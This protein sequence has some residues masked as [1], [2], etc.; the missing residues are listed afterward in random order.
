VSVK[1]YQNV[2]TY[3]NAMSKEKVNPTYETA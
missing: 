1:N 2:F 3:V